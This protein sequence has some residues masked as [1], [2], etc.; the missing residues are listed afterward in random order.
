MYS[1]TAWTLSLI[2]DR[3][4]KLIKVRTTLQALLQRTAKIA[5]LTISSSEQIEYLIKV[6]Y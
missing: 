2:S 5:S 3:N 1:Q 4:P 6:T